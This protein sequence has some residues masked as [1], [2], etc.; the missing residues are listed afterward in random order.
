M[1]TIKKI[2]D[3][4]AQKK[5]CEACSIDY[6]PEQFAYSGYEGE[7]IVACSQFYIGNCT[8]TGDTVKM[9]ADMSRSNLESFLNCTCAHITSLKNA[10]GVTD[11]EALIIMGKAVIY[12]LYY[13]CG[14][15]NIYF[16]KD[17]KIS[18][19]LIQVI[20]FQQTSDGIWFCDAEKLFSTP[21]TGKCISLDNI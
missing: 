10:N 13:S 19:R 7:K 15:K 21:C 16:T 4:E 8:D 1:L 3:K 12:H 6:E 2:L 11:V 14:I 9:N 5:I 17:E 18:D 20:G